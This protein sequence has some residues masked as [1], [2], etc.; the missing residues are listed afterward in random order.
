MLINIIKEQHTLSQHNLDCLSL[1]DLI[2]FTAIAHKEY[3]EHFYV[4]KDLELRYMKQ[5][6]IN[7][8]KI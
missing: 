8:I 1:S 6:K 2:E 5:E 3:E 7:I 4:L